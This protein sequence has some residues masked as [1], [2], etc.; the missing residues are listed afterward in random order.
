[1]SM[2]G[3]KKNAE[4]GEADENTNEPAPGTDNQL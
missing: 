3:K 2:F 1:M 4:D